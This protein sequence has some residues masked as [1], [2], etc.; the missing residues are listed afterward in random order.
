M[1]VLLLATPLSAKCSYFYLGVEGGWITGLT[2]ATPDTN[3]GPAAMNGVSANPM[4]RAG[5]EVGG[6][7]GYRFP[8]FFRSEFAY[9]FERQSYDWQAYFLSTAVAPQP[10]TVVQSFQAKLNSHLLFWNQYLQFGDFCPVVA[11]FDPYLQGGIGVAFNRLKETK[12]IAAGSVL[13]ARLADKTA[14]QLAFRF[15]LG[16]LVYSS[17]CW[18][19]DMGIQVTYLGEVRSGNTRTLVSGVT[20]NIGPYEFENNWIGVFNVG[21]KFGG[22][23]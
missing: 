12:E 15:G 14:T 18:M 21:V 16:T 3:V 9:T 23:P 22:R 8:C 17:S 13:T 6:N 5:F 10:P 2:Q 7:I 19:L 20:Q 4:P 1:G 11:N